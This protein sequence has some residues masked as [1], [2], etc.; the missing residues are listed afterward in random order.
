MRERKE[1]SGT[2]SD[3]G[4]IE[5]QSSIFGNRVVILKEKEWRPRYKPGGRTIRGK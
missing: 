4:K 1:Q 2:I 3:T 5:E